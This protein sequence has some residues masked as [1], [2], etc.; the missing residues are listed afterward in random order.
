MKKEK[1]ILLEYLGNVPHIRVLEYFIE[2]Y[3]WDASIE[4]ITFGSGLARN[5][6]KKILRDMLKVELIKQTRTVGRAKMFQLN[7]KNPTTEK[8]FQMTKS[9]VLSETEKLVKKSC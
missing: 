7:R 8:L 6:V 1:S 9:L 2:N 3:L 4:D 5:T